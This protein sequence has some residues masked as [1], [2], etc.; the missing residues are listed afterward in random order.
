M[1]NPTSTTKP[2]SNALPPNLNFSSS[3]FLSYKSQDND[4]LNK[5][6]THAPSFFSCRTK[7]V[8]TVQREENV[9]RLVNTDS[10]VQQWTQRGR[11][12]W[13]Q[14]PSFPER[15]AT[16]PYRHVADGSLASCPCPCGKGVRD[17][18]LSPPSRKPFPLSLPAFS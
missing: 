4:V 16:P 9:E 1:T 7:C 14:D 11:T 17:R 18:H 10:F 8:P 5:R 3:C 6:H 2:L 12:T 13:D 15:I